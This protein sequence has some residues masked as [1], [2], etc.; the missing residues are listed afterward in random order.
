MKK[1]QLVRCFY[2]SVAL[3][4][5]ASAALA[6]RNAGYLKIHVSPRQAYVFIDGAAMAEGN[7]KFWLVPGEHKIGVYNY[8]YQ[9]EVRTVTITLKKTLRLDISL[10]PLSGTVS[11]HWGRIQIEG[12]DRAA[13]LLNGKTPDFLV[14]H[15]D[16]FNHDIWV[17]QELL[18]PPGNHQVT[19]LYGD[20]ELWSGA[21]KVAAGQRVI[22]D[23]RKGGAVRT[24]E[25]PR[26]KKMGSEALPRFRAGLAN[27]TVAVG[28]VETEVSATPARVRCGEPSELA[29][30]TSGIV[31]AQIKGIGPVSPSG[32]QKVQP[33]QT[34]TY[35]VTASGPGGVY[36]S[37][38][39]VTVDNSLTAAL[40][41]TPAEL[42]YH[43]V[44]D[45]VVEQGSGTVSWASSNADSV[46]LDPLGAVGTSGSQ[47]VQAT[48]KKTDPGPVDETITY[49]LRAANACGGSE[50]H[51]ATLH[52][53]GSIEAI[54][55]A[56]IPRASGVTETTLETRLAMNSVYFPT[57]LPT[58]ANP[59]GKLVKSQEM[60]LTELA[61]NF[62][63]YLEFRAD[64][65]L[66]LQAH[67]DKRGS[68]EFNKALSERRSA[69]VKK[70]LVGH[71]VPEANIETV[72]FGS[73]HNLDAE[74]VKKLEEENPNLSPE[75]RK[76]ILRNLSTIVLV[77]NRRVD[78][79]LSTTGQQSA[80]YLPHNA[81]DFEE[82]IGQG[83]KAQRAPKAA[84]AAPKKK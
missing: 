10:Q 49:T 64:A 43:R 45:K 62:K 68:V 3:I 37:S 30:N 47:T 55:A 36:E 61:G 32:R 53:T 52:I 6:A 35:E 11:A 12:A 76:K 79:V 70:A 7:G 22:I 74:E 82:L 21:V 44:G 66:I 18:V 16:E 19:L 31:T 8:G 65:H 34:T 41:V 42:R 38:A 24:T 4:V 51:T 9:P 73:V 57:G 63:K 84:K 23:A 46:S 67:A 13:V 27:T 54:Q 75:M 1:Q 81:G 29:W 2:A 20:Q 59:N 40:S 48:P 71:G 78:V 80:R 77:S 15:G 26:G 50:A 72:A 39:T 25:W 69:R 5:S 83:R 14:G 58:K 17:K 56:V 28:P 33:T 60:V